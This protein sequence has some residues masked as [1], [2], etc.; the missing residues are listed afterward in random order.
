MLGPMYRIGISAT[1]ARKSDE[2]EGVYYQHVGYPLVCA[3]LPGY[4]VKKNVWPMVVNK[5]EYSGPPQFTK[6]IRNSNDIPSPILMEGQFM[7]D[8]AR[9]LLICGIAS[10]EHRAGRVT[11][12]FA[13]TRKHVSLLASMIKEPTTVLIGGADLET[14]N[15]ATKST[16]V[17]T[18]YSYGVQSI[19]IVAMNSL[20]LATSRLDT[21]LDQTLGRIMREGSNREIVRHVFDIVDVE[22]FTKR[23][24]KSR[25]IHYSSRPQV[26]IIASRV[27]YTEIINTFDQTIER[28]Y[29]L[30]EQAEKKEN[31]FDLQE[32]SESGDEA[33]DSSDHND[34]E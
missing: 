26:D 20:I 22:T 6:E 5:V 30:T 8:T 21:N 19:S 3:N 23:Q 14:F 11:F 7:Q 4:E 9:N 29:S 31:T 28:V 33:E 24:F 2:M 34:F 17:L 1:P 13:G 18:T 32:S 27:H 25:L 16:I 10:R 12:I 15:A